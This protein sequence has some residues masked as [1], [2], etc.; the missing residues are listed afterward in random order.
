MLSYALI[1]HMKSS[2]CPKHS[3]QVTQD[4]DTTCPGFLDVTYMMLCR[5]G[6]SLI[7]TPQVGKDTYSIWFVRKEISRSRNVCV[8]DLSP[9]IR[10]FW[11]TRGNNEM[12]SICLPIF[13]NL[14]THH[15]WQKHAIKIDRIT[16]S[17]VNIL[18]RSTCLPNSAR[19]S[20]VYFYIGPSQLDQVSTCIL[21]S[22]EITLRDNHLEKRYEVFVSPIYIFLQ[23]DARCPTVV[24][25]GLCCSTLVPVSK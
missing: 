9:T 12:L 7:R 19:E 3:Y 23:K 24:F 5:Y 8:E 13:T 16:T 1:F 18:I 25:S 22:H 20:S 17:A 4:S 11:N 10:R 2:S 14:S 21:F 6:S 15:A